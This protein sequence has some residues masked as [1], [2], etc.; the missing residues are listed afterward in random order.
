MRTSGVPTPAVAVAVTVAGVC[1]A[2]G[3]CADVLLASMCSRPW[4]NE[5]AL[6]ARTR[7]LFMATGRSYVCTHMHTTTPQTG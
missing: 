7:A 2:C 6:R 3:R 1:D 5:K 4:Q